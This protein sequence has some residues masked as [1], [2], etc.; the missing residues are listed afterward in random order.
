ML[1]FHIYVLLA[2]LFSKVSSF[3]LHIPR[4]RGI[5]IG[6]HKL[7]HQSNNQYFSKLRGFSLQLSTLSTSNSP[8]SIS[9]VSALSTNI[10]ISYDRISQILQAY[11]NENIEISDDTSLSSINTSNRDNNSVNMLIYLLKYSLK[12]KY[13]DHVIRITNMLLELD[14]LSFL[15]FSDILNYVCDEMSHQDGLLLLDKAVASNLD[16]SVH[17]FSPLLKTCCNSRNARKLF[18]RMEFFGFSPNV[19]SF[20]T[21]IKSCEGIFYLSSV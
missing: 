15:D 13:S 19:I 12:A 8:F 10:N 16:L 3:R 21:A 20:T 17:I 6:Y 11:E 1:T 5:G 9:E 14:M 7:D 4:F 2:F 18:Q